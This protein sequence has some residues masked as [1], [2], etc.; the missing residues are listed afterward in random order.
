[1]QRVRVKIE[2]LREPATA[3]RIAQMGADAVG[4]VFA[5]SPRWVSPEQA[6]AIVDILPPWV[7]AVGVFVNAEAS[8]INRVIER[9]HITH[10]QLHGDEPPEIVAQINRPCI[11]AFRVRDESWL[12]EVRQWLE[13]LTAPS[14]LAAVLLDA[15]DPNARGGTG[16]RFKWDLVADARAAGAM[17]GVDPIILA[18]GLDA[19]CVSGAIDLVKPWAVDVA[20]G[21]EKAPGVK[22]LALVEDFIRATREGEELHS[23]FW[24]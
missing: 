18:G 9:T 2:G 16:R 21:V 19:S 22:D 20:S 5:E 3:L 6:R 8:T 14:N 15:Y 13:A 24:M 12:G 11:K 10:V 17:A 1:V 7:A 4:L 23:E